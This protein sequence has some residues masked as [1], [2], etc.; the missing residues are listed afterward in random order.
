[1]EYVKSR[2]MATS[3]RD[4]KPFIKMSTIKRSSVKV[5][6]GEFTIGVYYG[7]NELYRI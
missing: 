1:M 2:I 7:G 3:Y 5:K 6:K 4:V